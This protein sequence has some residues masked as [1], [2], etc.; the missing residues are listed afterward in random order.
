MTGLMICDMDGDYRGI[1]RINSI[2]DYFESDEIGTVL[3]AFLADCADPETQEI[4]CSPENIT[5]ASA[6]VNALKIAGCDCEIVIYSDTADDIGLP[7]FQFAGYDVADAMLADSPLQR[8]LFSEHIDGMMHDMYYDF[9]ANTDGLVLKEYRGYLNEYSLFAELEPAEC[10]AD[11]CSSLT[12]NNPDLFDGAA[13]F[14]AVKV[15][16]IN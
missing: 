5:R 2:P 6:A 7:G 9:F 4:L 12:E 3:Q 13:D 14:K 16:L 15:Y 11:Y 8:G 10:I 1:G